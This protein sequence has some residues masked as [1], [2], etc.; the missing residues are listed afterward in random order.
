MEKISTL[1][2]EE[3]EYFM[4][5]AIKEAKKAELIAEVPIGAVV[6]LNGEIIGRGHNLRETSQNATAHAEMMAIQQACA[7]LD[8]FRL[9][10]TQL[11]VTL[12]PCPMC[13]GA[14]LLSRIDE[15]YFGAYDPKGG[16]AGSLLN[17][18]EDQRFNHWCYLESRV[19]E[20]ECSQLL[21]TFFKA[22]RQRKKADK[23][24]EKENSEKD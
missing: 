23:Q 13:S 10:D 22:L 20:E 24:K 14:I 8:N 12:E 21:K 3:K 9:E 11:F 16:T 7:R 5:E 4:K 15:V 19:L 18:L 6:V 17:L 1:T 2:I